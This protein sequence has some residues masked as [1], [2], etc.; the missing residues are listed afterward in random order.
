MQYQ[1]NFYSTEI[2]KAVQSAGL[3]SDS[4]VFADAIAKIP[5]AEIENQYV[6]QK[7]T[8][9][10]LLRF[11]HAHFDFVANKE[12]DALPDFTS[13]QQYISA[14]WSRLS[15]KP[16][17]VAKGSLL[18]LPHPYVV[19]GGRFNEIYYWDSYFTALGLLDENRSDLVEGML[20]NFVSLIDRIGHVPNGNRDY[21]QSRSQPPVTALMV[22]LLWQE[23]SHDKQWLSRV[24]QALLK[25]HQFWQ[26][27]EGLSCTDKKAQYRVVN[28]PCGGTLN[29]YWDPLAAPRPESFIEDIELAAAVTDSETFYQHIRAACESGWDFSSRWLANADDLAS[30]RTTDI[31]PVDLNAL[32]V[33]LESQIARCFEKLNELTQARYY[34]NLASNRS[35]LIQKYCWCDEKG[36]FFDVDLNDYART[37]V[38]SLAG[39]VPMFA[40]LVT[41]EQAEHIGKKLEAEFL[42][43]GGLV[44]TLV[45]TSQQWDSP[46]GWAPLQWFA[47]SGLRAYGQN[48]LAKKIMQA[49]LYAVETGFEQTGCLLEKYNMV[50]PD[51]QASGGEYVVQQGFGW[52]NGVTSRF[53]RLLVPEVDSPS[54]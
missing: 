30:I 21:Y 1:S 46:N 7:P 53:Y 37:T 47:V 19:P 27:G 9:E 8:G 26:T 28:M 6:M 23:K 3:F 25:E 35:A 18:P 14:L 2:F 20:D 13:A 10:A 5:L 50:E 54:A 48:Q 17:T 34:A 22:D 39:V 44:S 42:Q 49:W 31:I 15:R 4:K 40:E 11:V 29:R 41:P 32:L 24:T 16:S 52:T 43:Q 51:K 36:W 33:L 38:E 45:T 12:L